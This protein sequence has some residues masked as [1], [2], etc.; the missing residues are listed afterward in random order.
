MLGF[1][2]VDWT[3]MLVPD[4]PLVEIF[5]RGTLTYLALFLLL[6]L[7]LKRQSGAMGVTDLLVVVMIADA[8]QNAMA[9]TYTSITDGVLLVAT[10]LFWCFA[11]DWLGYRFPRIERF[12]H[13]PPLPLV[14]DG[15]LL[16]RNM[17]QELVTLDE[18]M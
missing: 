4:T 10:I 2:R 14:K 3:R 12:L 11:L 9:G 13:P 5:L 6:R 16:R 15:C 18:M 1:S 7:F 17:R 8:A